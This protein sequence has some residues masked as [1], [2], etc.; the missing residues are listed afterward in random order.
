L[1]IGLFISYEII[2]RHRGKLRAESEPKKGSTFCFTLP[3]TYAP[4][5]E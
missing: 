4:P 1:G 3:V 5:L 2:Q